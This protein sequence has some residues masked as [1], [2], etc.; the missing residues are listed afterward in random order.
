MCAAYAQLNFVNLTAQGLI[1]S[2]N[3]SVAAAVT[4]DLILAKADFTSTCAS[5]Q[6]RID[7]MGRNN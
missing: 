3:T 7:R 4:S 6:S 2:Y 1:F 5:E